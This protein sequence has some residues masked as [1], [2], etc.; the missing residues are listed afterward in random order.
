MMLNRQPYQ[1]NYQSLDNTFTED[2]SP[3]NNT[4]REKQY[5]SIDKS[6]GSF[7]TYLHAPIRSDLSN[8]LSPSSFKPNDRSNIHSRNQSVELSRNKYN[9]VYKR[10]ELS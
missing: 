9:Y 4:Y 10:I 7:D 6:R 1:S 8:L 3:L 5:K 2:F